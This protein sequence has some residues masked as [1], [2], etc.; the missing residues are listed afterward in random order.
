MAK[1]MFT[2]GVCLLTNGKT[3][4]DDIESAFVGSDFEIVK[5]VP[6]QND[7]RFGGPTLV[8]AY[9]PDVNGYAAIDVVDQRWPDSMG[10]PKKDSITFG[11]WSMGHFGP[12]A[13]PGGLERAAQHCYAWEKGPAV[14]HAHRGFIRMSYAFGAKDSDPIMPADYDALAELIFVT[15]IVLELFPVAG[16]LCYFNPNG[17]VLR[18]K[19][20]FRAMRKMCKEQK[21]TPLPLWMNVRYFQANQRFSLMD[22][23]GNAQLD[24]RDVEAIFPQG[25]IDPND[26][27]YYV[28]NVSQYLLGHELRDGDE[29][30]GPGDTNLTWT[31]EVPEKAAAEPP[32]RVVRLYP[33]A[34]RR[35]IRDALAAIR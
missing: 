31:I 24:L 17:E 34:H 19:G 14:A 18:D 2:Q 21:K 12:Y 11:A 22:S 26:I 1:G 30:D 8:I 29:I 5:K 7:W 3:N 25:D 15:D 4:I 28:R 13:F 23:V 9:D 16:V 32:R 20:E 35:E 33:K 10:D 27:D 6:A